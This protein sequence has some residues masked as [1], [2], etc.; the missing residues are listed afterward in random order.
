MVCIVK[1]VKKCEN[2]QVRW[3]LGGF[4]GSG[5]SGGSV[6][7]MGLLTSTWSVGAMRFQKYMV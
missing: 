1:N 2:G 6:W 5:G 7:V 4:G 3:V